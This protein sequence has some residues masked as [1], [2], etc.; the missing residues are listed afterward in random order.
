MD[1]GRT[2]D[3][4]DLNLYGILKELIKP[5]NEAV[6]MYLFPINIINHN[7]QDR[8]FTFSRFYFYLFI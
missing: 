3:E 6:S 1:L 4:Y 2:G 7:S 5:Y 8:L